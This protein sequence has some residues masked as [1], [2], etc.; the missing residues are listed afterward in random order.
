MDGM[1]DLSR[2]PQIDLNLPA[3]IIMR[4]EKVG[5][6]FKMFPDGSETQIHFINQNPFLPF[7]FEIPFKP[8]YLNQ[9]IERCKTL[10]ENAEKASTH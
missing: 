6:D 9:F 8:I 2:L 1:P 7:G 5:M 4:L 3:P 10:F